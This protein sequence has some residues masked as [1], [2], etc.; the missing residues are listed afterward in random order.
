MTARQRR[1]RPSS[2]DAAGDRGKTRTH[3]TYWHILSWFYQR[4]T[5]WG[6]VSKL[7]RSHDCTRCKLLMATSAVLSISTGLT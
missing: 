6:P 7:I 5:L 4:G 2:E 3:C 1:R